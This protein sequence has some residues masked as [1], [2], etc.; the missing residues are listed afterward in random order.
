M[1][2]CYRVRRARNGVKGWIGFAR[3]GPFTTPEGSEFFEPDDL[4]FEFGDS[5]ESVL[6]KLQTEVRQLMH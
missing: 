6:A 1:A 2:W 3:Q 5:E 4:W